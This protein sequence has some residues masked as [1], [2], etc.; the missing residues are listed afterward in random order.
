M[1]IGTS[2]SIL[3]NSIMHGTMQ[4]SVSRRIGYGCK[5]FGFYRAAARRC[6]PFFLPSPRQHRAITRTIVLVLPGPARQHRVESG[7]GSGFGLRASGSVLAAML[8]VAF[9]HTRTRLAARSIIKKN[10]KIRTIALVY[11]VF[12]WYRI[13][14]EAEG[15]S[16]TLEKR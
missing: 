2:D 9:F 11:A 15:R 1:A 10:Q 14:Q 7:F 12:A 4:G 16:S 13:G 8:L 3:R 6:G 5:L